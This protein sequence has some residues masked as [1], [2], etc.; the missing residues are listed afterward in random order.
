MTVIQQFSFCAFKVTAFYLDVF[1]PENPFSQYGIKQS[2]FLKRKKYLKRFPLKGVCC[3]QGTRLPPSLSQSSLLCTWQ[4]GILVQSCS[5][6]EIRQK[7]GK[8][9][10][11][12]PTPPASVPRKEAALLDHLVMVL[13]Y[14]LTSRIMDKLGLDTH[15]R[16][17]QPHFA[18]PALLLFPLLL[19]PCSQSFSDS[20]NSLPSSLSP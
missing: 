13:N 11:G 1:S 7:C 10:F 14:H 18:P 17:S 8:K 20:R 3:G 16:S 15:S 6:K 2:S 4:R 5:E 12:Y 19:D 9:E